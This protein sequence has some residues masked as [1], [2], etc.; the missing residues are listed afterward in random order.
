M[1]AP[2]PHA[3]FCIFFVTFQLCWRG[4]HSTLWKFNQHIKS[5]FKMAW[6]F[7][8]NFHSLIKDLLKHSYTLILKIWNICACGTHV[9][10]LTFTNCKVSK[11]VSIGISC[12]GKALINGVYRW[13]HESYHV[14]FAGNIFWCAVWEVEVWAK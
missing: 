5:I 1:F 12:W 7:W 9:F 10:L 8:I 6:S 4:V 13:R 11:M 14:F 2:L 3:T